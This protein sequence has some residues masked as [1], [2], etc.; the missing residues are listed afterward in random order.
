MRSK[1][2]ILTAVFLNTLAVWISINLTRYGT[3]SEAFFGMDRSVDQQLPVEWVQPARFT[4]LGTRAFI[5]MNAMPLQSESEQA[6]NS[7]L[8]Y[9]VPAPQTIQMN[10]SI[11]VISDIYSFYPFSE[12][13]GK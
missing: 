7:A 6:S 2:L 8:F 12:L 3:G 11:N 9:H 4:K 5:T 1:S 13:M 10:P